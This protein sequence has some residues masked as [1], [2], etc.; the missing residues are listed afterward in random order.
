[1]QTV[2]NRFTA[3]LGAGLKGTNAKRTAFCVLGYVQ[4]QSVMV[5]IQSLMAH[6][7]YKSESDTMLF[8]SISFGVYMFM[9]HH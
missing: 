7:H 1:M 2:S 6:I 8:A 4:I 9:Y 5:Q 3:F